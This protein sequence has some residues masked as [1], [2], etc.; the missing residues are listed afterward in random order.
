MF[1]VRFVCRPMRKTGQPIYCPLPPYVA[2]IIESV[3]RLDDMFFFWTGKSKLHTAKG[4]W[5]RSLKRL[6]QLAGVKG[7]HAHAFATHLPW[8]CC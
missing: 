3:T 8:T 4:I 7:G 6:F 1:G 5:Q 2:R